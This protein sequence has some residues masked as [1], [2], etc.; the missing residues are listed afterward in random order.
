MTALFADGKGFH[1]LGLNHSTAPVRIREQAVFFSERLAGPL[2]EVR[3]LPGVE[4]AVLI[5]TCNR[6]EVYWLG[7]SG[8]GE[9]EAWLHRHFALDGGALGPHLYR[10]ADAAAVR[11]LFR[12]CSGL[13]SMVLGESEVLAQMK[14]Y[15]AVTRD[16]G[17]VNAQLRHLFEH[18]FAVARSVRRQTAIGVGVLSLPSLAL[19][20]SRQ[21]FSDFSCCS[22][23]FIGSGDMTRQGLAHFREAGFA[24]LSIANRSADKVADLGRRFA[25]RTLALSEVESSLPQFDVIFSSIAVSDPVLQKSALET[26]MQA[27]R[28]R[29]LLI[30]DIGVPPNVAADA[31]EVD[32]VFVYGFDDLQSLIEQHLDRRG[33]EARRAEALIDDCVAD[34]PGFW[35]LRQAAT[36]VRDYREAAGDIEKHIVEQGRQRIAAGMEAEQA[37]ELLAQSARDI[38]GGGA[39]EDGG[40]DDRACPD[41]DCSSKL[42]RRA[43]AAL[44]AGEDAAAVLAR[45]GRGAVRFRAHGPTMSIRRLARED[46]RQAESR[47]AEMTAALRRAL[48]ADMEPAGGATAGGGH[49][50]P[51]DNAANATSGAKP[52]NFKGRSTRPR[53]PEPTARRTGSL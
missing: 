24:S 47:A 15:L 3:G 13:D 6:T 22:A 2:S 27:R 31:A 29:P 1:A 26:A 11:H 28:R 51:A 19:R 14:K 40:R 45:F 16:L 32:G 17:A 44:A 37:L 46:W 33:S 49:R 52:R 21:V 48:K 34:Y 41:E 50:P 9:T 20:L 12:V 36:L 4:A 8:E 38:L 5:S 18:A 39:E 42:W 53:A 43:G 10:H 23:L 35:R 25:A 7:E 30:V